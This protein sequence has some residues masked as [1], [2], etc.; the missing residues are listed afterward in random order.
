[1]QAPWKVFCIPKGRK[2][3]APM[4]GENSSGGAID[5]LL[6]SAVIYCSQR[7]DFICLKLHV[8]MKIPAIIMNRK[9]TNEKIVFATF[10]IKNSLT[11]QQAMPVN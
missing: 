3:P 1:M 7:K 5:Q 8:P 2:Y 4:P 9:M 10:V 6:L 11:K